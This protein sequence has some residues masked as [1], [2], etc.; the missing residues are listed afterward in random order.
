MKYA[1][2]YY[3]NKTDV[4]Y[5]GS[6]SDYK[7]GGFPDPVLMTKEEAEELAKNLD[8]YV[9][10]DEE[11]ADRETSIAAYNAFEWGFGIEE[12]EDLDAEEQ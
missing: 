4:R 3:P 9:R 5:V 11:F 8:V 10:R 2:C 12:F 1:V 6:I 7:D